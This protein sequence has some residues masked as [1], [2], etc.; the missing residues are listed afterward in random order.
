MGTL[1]QKTLYFK[2]Y[3]PF[4]LFVA[5]LFTNNWN[6]TREMI[7]NMFF[8]FNYYYCDSLYFK[9]IIQFFPMV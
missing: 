8:F 9:S 5:C 6:K 4:G 7:A 3:F 1:F 2:K